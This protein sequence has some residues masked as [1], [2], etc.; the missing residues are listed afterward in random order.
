VTTAEDVAFYGEAAS[1]VGGQAHS[2]RSVHRAEDTV[3]LEQV[4][5]DGLLMAIGPAREQQEKEGERW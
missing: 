2:P 1:M 4:R 3:L 5:N